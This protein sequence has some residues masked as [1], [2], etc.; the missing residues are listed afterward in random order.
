ML[1]LHVHFFIVQL[2]S[3]LNTKIDPKLNRV[4]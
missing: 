3:K 2:N 4:N 1:H